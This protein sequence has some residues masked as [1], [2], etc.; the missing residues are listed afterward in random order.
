M[1]GKAYLLAIN[2]GSCGWHV[3]RNRP[4]CVCCRRRFNR[5]SFADQAVSGAQVQ[6]K[7]RGGGARSKLDYRAEHAEGASA[8]HQAPD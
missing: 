7:G 3:G 8:S 6:L 2:L 4:G 5:I 1:R